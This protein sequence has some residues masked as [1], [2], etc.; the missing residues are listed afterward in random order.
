MRVA[1]DNGGISKE[2]KKDQKEEPPVTVQPEGG[3]TYGADYR[4][5]IGAV[6]NIL[7]RQ[8]EEPVSV[9]GLEGGTVTLQGPLAPDVAGDGHHRRVA[10]QPALAAGRGEAGGLGRDR[11]VAARHQLAAGGGRLALNLG[12]HRLGAVDD[13]LH[14][15]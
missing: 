15:A 12:D 14:E 7:G 5:T 8:L 4:L 9:R 2:E 13:G 1:Q 11:Q 3:L 10:E 6:R